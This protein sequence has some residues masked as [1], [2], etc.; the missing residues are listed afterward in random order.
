M[1]ADSNGCSAS[2]GGKASLRLFN[3]GENIGTRRHY[4]LAGARTM[5]L[6]KPWPLP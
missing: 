1:G 5:Q 4:D 2:N 3:P 6:R